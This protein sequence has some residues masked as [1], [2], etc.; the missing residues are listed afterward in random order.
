MPLH[1]VS[2][3]WIIIL[4]LT[5]EFS[6][7]GEKSYR[8]KNEKFINLA[9]STDYV[10]IGGETSLIH[11]NSSLKPIKTIKQLDLQDQTIQY[12]NW[13]LTV[14]NNEILI[15]CSY[16]FK[17]EK[18]D[19]LSRCRN[20]KLDLNY[21]DNESKELKIKQPSAMRYVTST[22]ENA[23]ILM[24]AS[25]SCLIHTSNENCNA[26]S[27]YKFEETLGE[28]SSFVYVT[29]RDEAKHVN[30]KTLFEIDK[31]IY[32]L[33]N[34]FNPQER[35]SKLG[36]ICTSFTDAKYCP[37]EDTKIQC[38]HN[39]K[40][41]TDA[42]DA[43][44]WKGYIYIAFNDD[45]S[46]VICRYN[47]VDIK[48]KLKKSR[49]TRLECPYAAEN[50]YFKEDVLQYSGKNYCFNKSTQLCQGM[51]QVPCPEVT[52]DL[53][54]FCNN[55]FFG[56]VQG[57]LILLNDM[58]I[59]SEDNSVSGAVVK[60]GALPFYNHAVIYAGT[61]TGKIGKNLTGRAQTGINLKNENTCGRSQQVLLEP[62]W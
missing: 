59:F 15:E 24:I 41:Y 46:S 54:G 11:L 56:P 26:I 32:V 40:V 20:Y 22:M 5:S 4:T 52:D 51:I 14:Y 13:L 29:Y 60:L 43:V 62:E 34:N 17:D 8:N 30:F 58:I 38:I 12:K 19:E 45:S 28:L 33:F 9:V 53:V 37:Y 6:C 18:F 39:T 57:K 31:Y 44:S 7:S 50:N 25:S 16:K 21:F 35:H 55:H 3:L 36:K 2:G 61:T 1:T 27:S 47:L 49:Q 10:Y 23:D 48:A 42:Q